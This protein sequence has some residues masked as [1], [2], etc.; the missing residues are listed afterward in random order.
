[1]LAFVRNWSFPTDIRSV[2]IIAYLIFAATAIGY[3]CFFYALKRV[4][5]AAGSCLFFFKP[6]LAALISFLVL[7]ET[8]TITYF[9]GMTVS[10][11]SLFVILY[12]KGG[13]NG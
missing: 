10:M 8:L 2:S 13:K 6:I 1:M 11:L 9:V 7:R 12:D 3:L 5:V 4:S